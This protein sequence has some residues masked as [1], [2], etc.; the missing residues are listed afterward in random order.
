MDPKDGDDLQAELTA[1][2]HHETACYLYERS[3]IPTLAMARVL[4]AIQQHPT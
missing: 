4:G 2:L 1:S 3:E